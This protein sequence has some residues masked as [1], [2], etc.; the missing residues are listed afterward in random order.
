M[1]KSEESLWDTMKRNNIHIVG[2]SEEKETE[3]MLKAKKYIFF[4]KL[5]VKQKKKKN[6][7]NWGESYISRYKKSKLS[8]TGCYDYIV[9]SQ[10]QKIINSSKKKEVT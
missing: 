6:S 2:I 3:S 7:Q 4:K 1:K 5:Y 10:R 8:Q 9:K